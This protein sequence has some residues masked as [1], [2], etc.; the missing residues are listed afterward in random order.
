MPVARLGGGNN[1]A[2]YW[3]DLVTFRTIRLWVEIEVENNG[4]DVDLKIVLVWFWL[5][6]VGFQTWYQFFIL[7]VMSICTNSF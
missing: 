7:K 2:I 4:S 6:H 5:S 1:F 3:P